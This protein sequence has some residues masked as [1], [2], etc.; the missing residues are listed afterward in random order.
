MSITAEHPHE[1]IS[2]QDII[3]SL[4]ERG[5]GFALLIFSLPCI[6][7]P[8]GL[9]SAPAVILIIFGAQMLFQ[10]N[11]PWVPQW[12]GKRSVAR[13]DLE[14]II[15]RM[16][17]VLR[18]IE[19][20]CKPR[21]EFLIGPLGER[22]LGLLIII[23]SLVILMPGPGT[24]GPPGLAIAFLSIAVIERDGL[25]VF[26]GVVGSFLAMYLAITGLILFFNWIVPAVAGWLGIAW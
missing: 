10:Y 6:I 19:S 11:Q 21:L 14:G 17:P 23:L 1:R 25:L 9:S 5:F 8:P 26:A 3:D 24:N 12:V 16:V 4:G 20:W 7:A 18:R 22:L 2:I 15:R 13:A